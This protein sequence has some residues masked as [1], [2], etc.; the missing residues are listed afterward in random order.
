LKDRHVVYVPDNKDPKDPQ[1]ARPLFLSISS[2]GDTATRF[3]LPIGHGPSYLSRQ[4]K[5]SWRQYDPPYP[6]GVKSQSSFYL[7]TTTHMDAL[8]SHIIV[9][10]TGGPPRGS[11]G[12]VHFAVTLTAGQKY[13]VCQKPGRLN[14]TPYWA[15]EMPV[16]IVPDHSG[17]FNENLIRLL[18]QFLPTRDEMLNPQSHKTLRL[19]SQ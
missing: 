13:N 4:I 1:A 3:G 9:E 16:T 7:S 14:D 5:G 15:M 10:D 8:Q 11:S 17:I 12:A 2:L 18:A 19:M 6:F